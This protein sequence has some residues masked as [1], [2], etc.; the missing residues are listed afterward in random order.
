M[1]INE[2]IASMEVITVDDINCIPDDVV[3]GDIILYKNKLYTMC[4]GKPLSIG[5]ENYLNDSFIRIFNSI[6]LIYS[7]FSKPVHWIENESYPDL[8]SIS[9]KTLVIILN[10]CGGSGKDTF[11]KML[12]EHLVERNFSVTHVSSIDP[13]REL[14]VEMAKLSDKDIDI[15]NDKDKY[16]KLLSQLKSVWDDAFDGSTEYIMKKTKDERNAIMSN[17]EK[18]QT[19]FDFIENPYVIRPSTKA[20]VVFVHI[21]EPHNIN[22]L[23]LRLMSEGPDYEFA[24]IACLIHGRTNPEDFDNSSDSMVE[25][26]AY[27]IYLNNNGTLEDLDKKAQIL[28]YTIDCWNCGYIGNFN[29]PE[30]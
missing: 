17:A 27:D 23:K 10:G 13:M 9:F 3:D 5:N 25:N 7:G 4:D 8:S 11:E 19:I 15:V 24:Y 26:Y 21:R 16:R 18:H 28:A 12:T 1:N 29:P 20:Q 22:R 14:A 6:N 2:G 30:V